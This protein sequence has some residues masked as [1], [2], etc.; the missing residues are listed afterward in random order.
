MQESRWNGGRKRFAV[1]LSL[2]FILV[3]AGAAQDRLK[4]TPGYDQYQKIS[5]EM[6]GTVKLGRLDVKWAK[7]GKSFEYE[8]DGKSFRFDIAS[9]KTMEL[10]KAA[11]QS[12]DQ[13]ANAGYPERGRQFEY[14]LSP[15][16]ALKAFHRDR[17]L[18]LSD[19]DGKN[20]FAVTTDGNAAARIKYGIASWVYG[21]ELFQT[22]AMW[23]SPDG[24]KI[25]FYRFDE[26][27][28]RD[29]VLQMDQTKLYSTADIEAYPKAGDP[30][31]VADILI[32][33]LASKTITRV[34][35]RDGKPFGES[36]AMPGMPPQ[37]ICYERADDIGFGVSGVVTRARG[38]R[39]TFPDLDPTQI[40]MAAPVKEEKVV[41]LLDP[42][43]ASRRSAML[44]AADAVILSFQRLLPFEDHA[45]V[46]PYIPPFLQKHDGL[47]LSL[48]QFNQWVGSQLMMDGQV[49]IWPG[50]PVAA[51]LFEDAPAS[52]RGRVA[53]VRL[54]DQGVDKKGAPDAGFMP[55]MD[56]RAALTVIG[57][58]PVGPIG[59]QIDEHFG[60]PNG[61]HQREWAVGMKLVV[62]LPES[63]TLEP[64][65]VIHTF[66]FPEPEIFG[67]MYVYPD[68]VASLGIFVPSWSESPVRTAYRYMQHWMQHPYLWRHLQGGTMRSFG[69]K[70][71]QE[72]GRAG[73]PLLAGDGYARIGEGSGSTNVLTG[74]GVDE[75]WT[76]GT[77]LAEG[78]LELLK[79]GQPFTKANLERAYVDRR[80]ASWL[81]A[82]SKVAEHARDGFGRGFI[83]GMIGMGLSGMTAGRLWLSG[84]STP[85]HKRVK[86]LQ[87]F[88]AGKF[89]TDE[90]T[91]IRAEC[92]AKG[93]ALHDVLME[94]TGWP[95]IKYDGKLLVSHQDALLVGGKVQAPAGYADH[96]VFLYPNLCEECGVKVC[97]EMCSGQAI[98]ANPEG[99]VP[100]FDREKCLHCG[101]CLWN[102]AQA[103]PKNS[104]RGNIRFNAGAGGL[105]SAEN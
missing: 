90:L 71:L 67:F 70:S 13:R 45:F 102:C 12:A 28:L 88:Y 46:L 25:A 44:K 57:D 80:R 32:Y 49:Q 94:A 33:D 81:D 50:T 52:A 86:S 85:P 9:R 99:G 53:G 101:V 35:V 87:E 89:T 21:E 103:D 7:D 19:A 2:V 105:H 54:A 58:G 3:S 68:R 74:S 6:Y 11:D 5:R 47:L 23:W 72:S 65:T 82:E 43:G 30:N 84:K 96:V 64:G 79:S 73:E 98:T 61:H 100:I 26:S 18:W 66:G 22:T 42:I 14:A 20:E 16:K 60:M 75:A 59:R 29:F 38:I 24:K 104:E 15:D 1:L 40:P 97:V 93:L 62:D 34:D 91:Q 51:P 95:V 69:A 36:Q 92:T 10:P 8:R 83:T 17:N 63:C 39:A 4:K 41:Y 37:V 55:G 77:Q 48:G 56:I 76:T 31:P 27:R 78:V